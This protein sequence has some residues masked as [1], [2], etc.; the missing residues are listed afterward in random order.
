M[1]DKLIRRYF[2]HKLQK[3]LEANTIELT[4]IKL[5]NRWFADVPDWNGSINSLEMVFGSDELLNHLNKNGHFV[6]LKVSTE[7][8]WAGS[9]EA[10]L[11]HHDEF[12]GTYKLTQ[13][14]SDGLEKFWLCNVTK[15]VFGE[16][17]KKLYFVQ[18]A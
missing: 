2:N 17:P 9:M 8:Q 10:D 11:I 7:N 4:F 18:T 5:N 12:G 6:T 15:Y 13:P 1:F 3:P 16:H 14:L